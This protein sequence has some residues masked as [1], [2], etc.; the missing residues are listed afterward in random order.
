MAFACTGLG[1]EIDPE[2]VVKRIDLKNME[3]YRNKWIRI[4]LF[5]VP[6]L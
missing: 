6:G 4:S 2:K 3:V 1:W 5:T